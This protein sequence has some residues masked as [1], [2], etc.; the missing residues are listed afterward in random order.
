MVPVVVGCVD[1]C[2]IVVAVVVVVA[3]MVGTVRD[4]FVLIVIGLR[5]SVAGVCDTVILGHSWHSSLVGG[6]VSHSEGTSCSDWTETG[7]LQIC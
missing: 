5:C 4:C 6:L 1:G 2:T 3:M 7:E